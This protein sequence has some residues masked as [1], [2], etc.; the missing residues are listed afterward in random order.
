MAQPKN[1]AS[2]HQMQMKWG[3]RR[4]PSIQLP[5]AVE[6]ELLSALAGLLHSAVESPQGAEVT[7]E[8]EAHS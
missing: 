3:E 2:A 7:H 1:S 4:E 8:S 6:Q 5:R